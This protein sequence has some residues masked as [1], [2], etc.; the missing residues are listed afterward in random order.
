MKMSVGL[1]GDLVTELM[2]RYGGVTAFQRT[3]E[4]T[5]GMEGTPDRQ[6]FYNWR[7][8]QLPSSSIRLIRLAHLLDVDPLCLLAP[9]E[10]TAT[11]VIGDIF[12]SYQLDL[13]KESGLQFLS[14][15]FGWKAVWPPKEIQIH[16]RN[17]PS[18]REGFTWHTEEFVHDPTIK[19]GYYPTIV[20]TSDVTVI[21]AR[22]QTFHFAYSGKGALR[23]RWLQ[24]GFVVRHRGDVALMHIHGHIDGCATSSEE[25]PTLVETWFGP[26]PAIFRVASRHPFSLAVRDAGSDESRVRFPG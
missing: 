24:Y 13:A 3:W 8:G 26:G 23:S 11:E 17:R 2:D 10:G 20:L 6:T 18:Q 22:P 12:H 14:S 7:R 25:A 1:N 15:F 19:A 21:T 5:F 16:S 4:D 9:L